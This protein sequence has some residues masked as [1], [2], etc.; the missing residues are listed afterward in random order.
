MLQ[1]M[2]PM[3]ILLAKSM[4]TLEMVRTDAQIARGFCIRQQHLQQPLHQRQVR[5]LQQSI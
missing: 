5:Q 2:Q 4:F 1:V 3:Q